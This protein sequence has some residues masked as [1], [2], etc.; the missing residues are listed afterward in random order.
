MTAKFTAINAQPCQN[1]N[2]PGTNKKTQRELADQTPA[3]Q[4]RPETFGWWIFQSPKV[5]MFGA[6]LPVASLRQER[7][8]WRRP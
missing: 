1:F 7:G 4:P 3:D 8:V 6:A 5:A 2:V